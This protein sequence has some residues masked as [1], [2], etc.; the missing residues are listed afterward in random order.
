MNAGTE[1]ILGHQYY[2]KSASGTIITFTPTAKTHTDDVWMDGGLSRNI[3]D[4]A[5]TRE[6][7]AFIGIDEIVQGEKKF[8]RS[9]YRDNVWMWMN[10]PVN[11]KSFDYY[12][13]GC[14]KIISNC[15]FSS[16]HKCK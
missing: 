14:G 11:T 10:R 7:A 4:I 12:M 3:K 6:Q 13:C 9:Q 1:L 8:K 15:G 16:R 2:S 5:H